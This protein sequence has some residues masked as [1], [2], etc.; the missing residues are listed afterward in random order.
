MNYLCKNPSCTIAISK[1]AFPVAMNCPVCQN[2]L[3]VVEEITLLSE[4]DE[5]LLN[6]LPYVIAYPLQ[7]TLLEKNAP[8]RLNYFRDTFLNYLKYLGLLTASEFFNSPFKERRIVDLFLQN[9]AQPSFGSWNAFTRECLL[10][11]KTQNHTFFCPDLVEYYETVETGKKR[12]MY[13]GEIEV[14][15][16]YNG[17]ET[18]YIKQTATGI[19]MLINFRNRYLGHGLTLDNATSEKLWNEYFP[20]FRTLL[21]QLTFCEKFPMLKQEANVYYALQGI[22]IKS[23]EIKINIDSNVSIY[24]RNTN[25][26]MPII[27]FFIIPGELAIERDEIANIMSYESNNGKTITFFSPEGITKQTSGKLLERL[28]LLLR[29]KLKEIPFTP[30]TFT[31]EVFVERIAEENQLML[32]SLLNEKKVIEGIY[33]H[34]EEI[35][36]KL[37]EWI[38]ARAN[39]FFI[40]AEAGSG[41]TNLLVEIQ[42]QYA[43]RNLTSLLI[44]ASRMEKPSLKEELCY[45]L[46]IDSSFDIAQYSSLAG[47]QSEPIFILIDGLNESSNAEAIWQE[48]LENSSAFE[49]G[50]LKFIITS[51]ANSKIDIDRYILSENQLQYLYGENKDHVK[52]LSGFAFWLTPLDMKEMESAWDSYIA[53]DKNRFKPL[54][55]FNDIATFDRGLYLQINNPLVLRIFLETYKGKNLPKKGTKHLHVWKDWLVTFSNEEQK[56]MNLMIDAIWEQGENE[57]LLDDVLNN[58]NLQSYFLNDNLSAP[59]LRLLTLGWISRYVKDLI[60]YVSFTVEGLLLYLL[61]TKLN[62][63]NPILTRVEIDEILAN[64][65]KLQKSAIESFLCE[66]ALEGKIDLIT[67]LIDEGDQKLDLCVTPLLYFLKSQGVEKTIDKL[68][69]NPTEN[70]WIILE[71]LRAEIK[72]NDLHEIVTQFDNKILSSDIIGSTNQ[73]FLRI[74]CHESLNSNDRLIELNSVITKK[75]FEEYSPENKFK[76]LTLIIEQLAEID[77]RTAINLYEKYIQNEISSIKLDNYS[78]CKLYEYVGDAYYLISGGIK[79]AED[80]FTKGL[81]LIND[82]TGWDFEKQ[83]LSFQNSVA[84]CKLQKSEYI[85]SEKLFQELIIKTKKLLGTHNLFFIQVNS[86]YAEL[87]R[88]L[89]RF[90]KSKEILNQSLEIA[91]NILPKNNIGFSNIYN[92]LG[93]NYIAQTQFEEAIDCFKKCIEL[94]LKKYGENNQH[95]QNAYNNLGV[96]HHHFGELNEALNYYLKAN[97]ICKSINGFGSAITLAN[98]GSIYYGQKEYNKALIYL[99]ESNELETNNSLTLRK[100]GLVYFAKNEIES[101]LKFFNESEKILLAIQN[102]SAK[103]ELAYLYSNYALI[104]EELNDFNKCIEYCNKALE[105]FLSVFDPSHEYVNSVIFNLGRYYY[106]NSDFE[107]AIINYQKILFIQLKNIGADNEDV[108]TL[109]FNI[110]NCYIALYNYHEALKY[111]QSAY[112]ILKKGGIAF[113]IAQCYEALNDK[114]TALDYYIQSAEIRKEDI[115]LENVATQ[116]AVENS[117]RLAKELGKESELPEWIK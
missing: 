83:K 5:Q 17:G 16:S 43:E 48:I 24:N 40:A 29:D 47:M 77:S 106:L 53:K 88:L 10:Y 73:D 61:G 64:G 12:K 79:N 39:I 108:A 37:R 65:T 38:G 41:K 69:V 4:V 7:Q 109:N 105:I 52:S 26:S 18:K 87:M 19:G 70:D 8:Q 85:D 20:I 33:Q 60:V 90:D 46:N 74:S 31:K 35:E 97:T 110:G 104:Y 50:G 94:S 57:L 89:N 49:P 9:L 98:I 91:F 58:K 67:D 62:Q 72:K 22:E 44:R 96:A 21:E 32:K 95:L 56:F 6:N 23:F 55:S 13:N 25:S 114:E 66:Q 93:W 14:I 71:F 113:Q 28:N 107:N 75:S 59:Y 101:A 100:I 78:N 117:K 2:P 68:L 45:K 63:Q 3:Q 116:E 111:Y 11:L 112:A 27:P 15:D 99:L 51:R 76:F 42:K 36:I 103:L 81:N 82:K 102:D 80:I 86:N 1:A 30:E 54:F 92:S 84:C 34:R 115:G